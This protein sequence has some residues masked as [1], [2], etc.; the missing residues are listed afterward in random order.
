VLENQELRQKFMG[1]ALEEAR[2]AAKE[3]EVPIGA[4]VV[5]DGKII[6]KGHNSNRQ[7]CDPSAHAE[8]IAIRRACLAKNYHRLDGC[9]LYVTIEPCLMCLAA[10]SMARISKIHYGAN[11]AK[12]GAIA[13]GNS[14]GSFIKNSS[15]KPDLSIIGAYPKLEIHS[16]I[17]SDEAIELMQ[18]F[19]RKLRKD[20][21]LSKP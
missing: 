1:F 16:G 3:D 7:L 6:A 9:E 11:D 8:I 21:I 15:P 12:F 4:V 18:S 5:E 19:F 14:C 10:I 13:S 17:C 20:R 2:N